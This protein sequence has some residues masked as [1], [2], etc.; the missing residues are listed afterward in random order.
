MMNRSERVGESM[1]ELK[2]RLLI[3]DDDPHVLRAYARV[4]SPHFTA[5]TESN[6]TTALERI[7]TGALFD[8]VLCD[9]NLG[10]GM[11]GIAFFGALPLSLQ[12]HFVMY[13]GSDPALDDVFASALGERF[14]SKLGSAAA[15]IGVLLRAA[16]AP[17][18][19]LA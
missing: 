13:S 18:R 8:V 11:S 4:L 19:G 9:R 3:I 2:P 6:A 10:Q 12:R 7:R 16:G 1:L 14:F 5:E 17:E 15:L